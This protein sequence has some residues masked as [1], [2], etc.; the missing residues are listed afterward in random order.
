MLSDA[1]PK[2]IT[3]HIFLA[4]AVNPYFPLEKSD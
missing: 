1:L 4:P 3:K 2:M